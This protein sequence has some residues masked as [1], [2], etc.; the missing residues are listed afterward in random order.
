MGIIIYNMLVNIH[1]VCICAR[2][3]TYVSVCGICGEKKLRFG[4]HGM[5]PFSWG[6]IA[7]PK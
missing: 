1:D 4:I 3:M 5:A 7:G 6:D 2:H